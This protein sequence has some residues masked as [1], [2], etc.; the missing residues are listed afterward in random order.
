MP[1]QTQSHPTA[2]SAAGIRRFRWREQ[3]VLPLGLFVVA[4]ILRVW[5]V[6]GSLP[7]V[8]HVDEPA[9][10]E[11]AIRMVRDG[12]VNPHIF[13]Y[14]SLYYDLLA[15]TTKLH[16]WWGIAAGLYHSDQDIPFKNYGVTSVPA[17][18]VWG[19]TLTAIMGAASVPAILVL[20]QRMFG[21]R[22][23]L[24]AAVTLMMMA[25]H[26]THSHYITVDA[27]TS[28]WV[29][30]T[31]LG[32]WTIATNG[33]WRS[34]LL[35]GAALG[36]AAGTKYNAGAVVPAIVLAHGIHWRRTSLGR[37]FLRLVSSGTVAILA[38][39]ATTPYALLDMQTFLGDLRFNAIHYASGSH[40]DFTGTWPLGEYA[41]FYWDKGLLPT[42][43]L[44][45]LAGLPVLARRRPAQVGVLLL[46]IIPMQIMLLSYAVHFTRN[47]LP[48]LP[49]G[50]L[51]AAAGAVALTDEMARWTVGTTT[52]HMALAGLAAALVVPQ[53]YDTYKHLDYWSRPHTMVVA[54]ERIKEL[55]QGARIA[56]E[57][58]AT[59]FGSKMTIFPVKRITE[60][61]VDWYRTNGYRYLAA[62]DDLRNP[63]DSAAYAQIHAAATVVIAFPPRRVGVQPGPSGAIL[64]LGEH[65]EQMPFVR[66]ALSFG[67]QIALLGYEMTPGAPR[68]RISPLNGANQREVDS[69]QPVQIN[70]YWRGL[71]PIRVDYTLFIH[72]TDSKG[73]RVA[74]RDLPLRN[75]DYPSSHWREGE[76]VI[77]QA[78]MALPALPPGD[79]HLIIGLYDPASGA[80]LPTDMPGPELL[81]LHV[82]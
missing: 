20:G 80:A 31:I 39:L 42:G 62:N 69:G 67:T 11:V 54:S 22:V 9:V 36:L 15:A 46:A 63:G 6:G 61:S 13:R 58:P 52:Q 19:R 21:R 78:D 56:A 50:I 33:S 14:P 72:V 7:Y 18:Y 75:E 43:C 70:L 5:L 49:L 81:T 12:D 68:S 77:D 57:L 28:L 82:R 55:P 71:A 34:Y 79:Y 16:V 64:D 66:R 76:L 3:V 40:G 48:I 38:F 25:F 27:S 35:A 30:L 23:G 47:L 41:Y 2:G 73:N 44:L 59:L 26:V 8:E 60:H 65:L 4:L 10:L 32:A 37:P 45:L 29:I 1:M 17:L 53:A 51:L 24:L 74:Q